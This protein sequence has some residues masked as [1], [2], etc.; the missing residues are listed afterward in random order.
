VAR[1]ES[2][3]TLSDALAKHLATALS[4]VFSL[5][6]IISTMDVGK[7]VQDISV[8]QAVPL[9]TCYRRARQLVDE[10]ILVVERIVVTGEGKRYAVYRSSFKTVEMDSDFRGLSASAEL[11]EAVAEKFRR[12]CFYASYPSEKKDLDEL[13]G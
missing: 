6:I 13:K 12:W 8:E 5:R 10:G 3:I 9:S 11:N 7:T 4:D 2:R 1:A